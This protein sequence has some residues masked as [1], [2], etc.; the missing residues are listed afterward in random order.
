MKTNAKMAVAA[1][2]LGV[3]QLA[4][5]QAVQ[6]RV[7]D[8]G[9][10][11]WYEGRLLSETSFISWGYARERARAVGG[12]LAVLNTLRESEWVFDNVASNTALWSLSMGPWIGAIQSPGA[13]EPS[14]GWQWIDG[15]LLF[16]GFP[17][18]PV[19]QPDNAIY[20]GSDENRVCYWF[21]EGPPQPA[22]RFA[23][24]VETGYCTV[25]P[26]GDWV[27]SAIVEWSADCNNDGVVDYGQILRGQLDDVDAN[28]V[29]D[30]CELYR[31]PSDYPAIQAAIDA[32]PQGAFGIIAIAAGVYNESFSLS[33]KNVRVQG[34]PNNDTILDGTGLA[35]SIVRFTGSE[36]ATAGLENLVFRNGT[37]GSRIVPKA[38]FAVG[39]AVYGRDS[40]AFIRNCRFEQNEA[41]FGGAVYLLRCDSAV[42]GCVFAG[43][44]AL[45]D[46]G[47]FFAYEC[48]G[49]VRTSDF[50][51]NSCGASGSGNGGAFK[52]VGAKSVGGTFLLQDSTITGT[53]SGVDGAAVHHFENGALGTAGA[54]R[55]VDTE[56]SGNTT[57]VGAGGVRHDGR[58]S[59][60]VLSGATVVCP[61]TVRNID[62][63]FLLE[64]GATVC[65]CLTDVTGDGS[66]NGGD[67]G[68]V[69]N[70]WGLADAQG[71]GD[72]NHD[73]VVDG[74]DLALV[75]GSWGACP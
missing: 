16:S 50:T 6:W 1:V 32:V 37:A 62:G 10:G 41:D 20:C 64:G 7:E 70:A 47:A 45:T 53:M 36:P 54:L 66:V 27:T 4:S 23:D 5:G 14:G 18:T 26:E 2:S 29:P 57:V 11:H 19:H 33:G 22:N 51:A 8:G 73:G 48:A 15:T 63:P 39:G 69:L 42:E 74:A 67:L 13:S 60:L 28:G 25:R 43:N 3:S 24:L 17:W 12:D 40:S 30:I 46:G 65:D 21:G 58:Q 35:A 55:I 49:F 38:I 75:L 56:I 9:N 52:A 31:V 59:S 68:V 71:T 72:V 34:A 61:N 44:E